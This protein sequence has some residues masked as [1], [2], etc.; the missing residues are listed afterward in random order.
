MLMETY[1][2]F[3][4]RNESFR[5]EFCSASVLPASVGCRNHCPVCLSSK[6]VDVK[7]GDRQNPCHG[8]LA[9][10]GYELDSRKGLVILFKCKRCGQSTR[11]VALQTG[12]MPDDYDKILALTKKA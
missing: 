11:N 6:H 7:P 1:G 4:H 12:D 3:T 10:M 5:C 2:N 9:A 8:Q